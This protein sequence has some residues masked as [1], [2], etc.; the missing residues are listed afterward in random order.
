MFVWIVQRYGKKIFFKYLV[1]SSIF[2]TFLW[3]FIIFLY[4]VLSYFICVFNMFLGYFLLKSYICVWFHWLI[5]FAWHDKLNS[6]EIFPHVSKHY[7]C[8]CVQYF[9][10]YFLI[11][12]G[13]PN[14]TEK[15]QAKQKTLS[16]KSETNQWRRNGACGTDGILFWIK[17]RHWH[18]FKHSKVYN[19]SKQEQYI[20]L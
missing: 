12:T 19:L 9:R 1:S 13:C 4:H 15:H 10:T 20:R 16:F 17:A 18:N 6:I 8:S 2:D 7:W 14:D 3:L 11:E 5:Y